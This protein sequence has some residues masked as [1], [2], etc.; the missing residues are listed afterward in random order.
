MSLLTVKRILMD[1][2]GTMTDSLAENCM[3]K[4]PFRHLTEL[5]MK[6]D[7]ISENEAERKIRSC[8]DVENQCLSE[9]LPALKVDP[10]QYFE[11][12][13]EDL[14]RHIVIPEDTV[15]FLKTMRE[16]GIPV[17]TATTNSRFITLAKLAVGGL[18]DISG[19][20]YIAAYH[21]GCEFGDPAGKFSEHYFPNILK[22]HGYDPATLMML[23]DEPKRDLYPA[24]K[25]GIRY[26]VIIDRNQ[27][28]KIIRRDG[29][30]FIH[31]LKDLSAMIE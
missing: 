17:C 30:I 2:D 11:A 7:R 20:P 31:S 3:E 14:A 10:V 1:V 26:G 18:A 16:R 22:H 21:P 9:F 24:L 4:S 29:G 19:S 25:A 6:Q 15:F 8:G 13:K 28:E 12:I 5:V 27:P 23:G